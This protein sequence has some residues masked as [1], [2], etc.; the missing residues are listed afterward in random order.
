MPGTFFPRIF[1]WGSCLW[2]RTP[3]R[4]SV[5]TLS[6]TQQLSHT[7]NLLTHT[8]LSHTTL[9]HTHTTLSQ[10]SHAQ[11]TRTQLSHT[12]LSHTQQ[13]PHNF[14]T[15]TLSH[16]ANSHTQLLSHKQLAHTQLNHTQ[17]SHTQQSPHNSWHLWHWVASGGALGSRGRRGC[18][19]D[20]RGI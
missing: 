9:A 10:L 14:L 19:C 8:T 15:T 6:L 18:L 11:L 20:R 7:H 5:A 4:T 1:V 17:L 16:T 2:L 13:P 12:Q 3:V